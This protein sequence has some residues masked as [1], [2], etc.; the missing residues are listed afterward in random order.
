MSER[1]D[2]SG[3]LF[4]KPFKRPSFVIGSACL[5]LVLILS[6]GF[7]A[8]AQN[9]SDGS[10]SKSAKNKKKAKAKAKA[11]AKKTKTVAAPAAAPLKAQ[12][13]TIEKAQTNLPQSHAFAEPVKKTGN[14]EMVKPPPSNDFYDSNTKE[15]EYEALLNEEISALYHL[16]EQ[17]RH[18]ANRGEIWLRL[19]ERY[20][21]K[22][23]LVDMKAQNDYDK[24]L[25]D[26]LNQKSK[27]KPKLDRGIAREYNE[28]AVRLYEWFI[29]DFPK[30][31]KVDQALF[32]L[33]YNQFELGNTKTGEKYYTELVH[34][35]P[36]SSFITE[37]RFALGEYY[38]ENEQWRS[39]LENY[40]K[41]VQAKNARLNTFALYKSAW[42]L[43][44]LNKMKPA[45]QALERVIRLS[46]S[47][48]NTESTDGHKVVNKV[49][50][51]SEALKDYVPFYAEAGDPNQAAEE[52][53]RL[54]GDDKVT[55]QMLE[56]LA[57]IYADSGNRAASR[58]LFKKL[59]SMNPTGER[60]AEYQYQIV[61][62]YATSDQKEFRKE[63][64]IWLEVFGASSAWARENNKNEKL[65]ADVTKLQ[66]T[67]V[68][69][70]VL[71]LHQAAQNSRAP[72][73]QQ[74]AAA[75]YNQYFKY[76]P[77]SPKNIEMR[78]FDAELLFD[79]GKYEEASR[80]YTWVAEKDLK[81]P[82]REKS[83][84][85]SLLALEKDLPSEKDI[86]AKRGKSLEKIPFDPPVQRFEK[87]ALRYIEAFPKSEKTPDIERRLGVLY[88]SYNHFDEAIPMFE[89]V[90]RENPKSANAEIAGN[91]ILDIYKLKGDMAGFA[92]KGQELLSNPAIAN[93][94]FGDKIRSMMER[95]GYVR[96]EKAEAGDPLKAAKE[97]EK[98]A[99]SYK[100]SDLAAAARFKAAINYEKAGD[101]AS[102]VRMHGLVVATPSSD[103]KIKT[104][105]N[106]SRNALARI[107]QQTGQLELA[108][109]EYQSYAAA[110]PKDPKAVN[111]YY[112]AGILWDG[113]GETAAAVTAYNAYYAASNKPDRNEV[114]FAEA[115]LFKRKG[116]AKQAAAYYEKYLA[117]APHNEVHVIQSVFTLAQFEDKAGK[118]TK[119][120]KGYQET[121]DRYKR[122]SAATR[123]QVVRF[124]AESRF[125][126]AQETLAKLLAV[127]FGTSDKQQGR[128]ATDI[129][130]LREKYLSEM[131]D[132]IRFDN[133]PFIVA[134][135]ASSG[136]MY[137]SIARIFARIPVPKGFN[138]DDAAKY[139]E[140]IQG[141][142]NS[143]NSEAKNAYKAAVDKAQELEVYS[144]WTRAAQAGLTSQDPASEERAD[145]LTSEVRA[146]DWMGL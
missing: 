131:K 99:S 133:G 62:S 2:G 29:R 18:S 69:N 118:E 105:Q 86:D 61:L 85:N 13:I 95:A 94:K 129:K 65:V 41:V 83:I 5:S 127:K 113:L 35:F 70:H 101:L 137:D 45:L 145:E 146:S 141:Q 79:M 25:K 37:S 30:D 108:A 50:L 75:S 58:S 42:C 104:A 82:Y 7:P 19:G 135:L 10:Q 6:I 67:T 39:A 106:D 140:L 91:L 60:S 3:F 57:F 78:F 55:L 77:N 59:I 93:S 124:A 32:F 22:A 80:V 28:K 111:A 143:F 21:E 115:E 122:S 71:Q 64:E 63:L 46:R 112:N 100:Q 125:Q 136:Q 110:N 142:I 68:R 66:E 84:V 56:R 116:Q 11:A 27:A 40:A 126:L 8:R 107:Y 15:A 120:R 117:S 4:R 87:A 138:A 102:A 73:S 34:R 76:F 97:F 36:D 132:V 54:S 1:S 33:G 88:Y 48:G 49:R 98:F 38:F 23:R 20:V 130:V 103:P 9:D 12:A 139:K 74:L 144:S 44:R 17:N 134:A 43:Y 89:R 26:Y 128:A 14:L 31:P 121:I 90:I 81:G 47:S 123:D 16:S 96:A 72:Y 53:K 114:L 119:A 52:F 51:A 92:D 24:K 109:K